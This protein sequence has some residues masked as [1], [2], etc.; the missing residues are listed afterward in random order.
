MDAILGAMEAHPDDGEMQNIGS[1]TIAMIAGEAQLKQAVEHVGQLAATL[2]NNPKNLDKLLNAVKLLG[3]LALIDANVGKSG[4][5]RRAAHDVMLAGTDCACFYRSHAFVCC[6][7]F[8]VK[9]GAVA[10]LIAAFVAASKLPQSEKRDKVL[11]GATQGLQRLGTKS[12]VANS[13]ITKQGGMK[14]ILP[15]SNKVSAKTSH[16][17][18]PRSC[19]AP[20]F[21]ARQPCNT[22]CNVVRSH[23][24]VSLYV[25]FHLVPRQRRAR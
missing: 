1:R 10:A 13:E 14:A 19:A 22:A 23:V 16:D 9:N 4:E 5:Q 21:M 7:D 6:P 11:V 24:P 20:M 18:R 12:P 8:L 17:T 25:S 3:N 2:H 15:V